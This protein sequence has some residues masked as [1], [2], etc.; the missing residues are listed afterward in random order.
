MIG[1]ILEAADLQLGTWAM[2][3]FI[4]FYLFRGARA[5]KKVGAI[6]GRAI[7][8]GIA[9]L[10]AFGLASALGWADIAPGKFI[11]DI[12]TAGGFLVEQVIERLLNS[13]SL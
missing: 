10:V 6:L 8:Y 5:G 4:A 9:I 1:T 13:I 2:L 7:M 11:S 12:I 3:L